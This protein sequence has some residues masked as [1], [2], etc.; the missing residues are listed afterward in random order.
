M[1]DVRFSFRVSL[2]RNYDPQGEGGYFEYVVSARNIDDALEIAAVRFRME[3][4]ARKI[5]DYA[6]KAAQF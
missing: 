6:S 2:T 4:P 3:H 1:S 5:K